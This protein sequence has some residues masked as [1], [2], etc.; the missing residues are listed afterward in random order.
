MYYLT[1][2]CNTH[3]YSHTYTHVHVFFSVSELVV[4]LFQ[5]SHLEESL[6]DGK[7]TRAFEF[8]LQLSIGTN[9]MN[10][11]CQAFCLK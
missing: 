10:N 5:T 6:L 4:F 11:R 1:C 7:L 2:I 3:L 8:F 9:F